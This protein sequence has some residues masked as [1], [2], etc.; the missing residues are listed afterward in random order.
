MWFIRPKFNESYNV[1]SDI[2][3]DSS[4]IRDG[5]ILYPWLDM[6]ACVIDLTDRE[7]LERFFGDSY[8]EHPYSF[9]ITHKD[10]SRTS[11]MLL[12]QGLEDVVKAGMAI[13]HYSGRDFIPKRFIDG[14]PIPL[15]V[16]IGMVILAALL[17]FLVLY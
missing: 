2:T 5:A 11:L 1:C 15:S 13:N 17:M 10:G 9:Y 7:E 6:K 3:I 4:G 16:I 8:D 12:G 14:D